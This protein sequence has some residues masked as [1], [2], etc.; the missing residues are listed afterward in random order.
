MTL[1]E[2]K[3]EALRLM[4][5]DRELDGESVGDLELDEDYGMLYTGTV[6]AINRALADLEARR[7]LPLKRAVLG[8]PYSM[9]PRTVEDAGPYKGK[10][11]AGQ[12]AYFL[13]DGIADLSLPARLAVMGENYVDEDCPY[14]FEAGRLRV[15]RYDAGAVYELLY[16]PS[17]ARVTH[18]TPNSTV[19]EL[20]EVLAAALPYYVKADLYRA[21][22]PGEAN[23]ARN[24]YESAVAQY[25]SLLHNGPQGSVVNVFEGVF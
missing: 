12:A 7:I 21:D 9:R 13:L 24:W 14:V 23:D 6:G 8:E 19:L 22:E 25:A 15:M 11:V 16:H 1:G 10:A 2:I 17:L 3:A 18:T 5:V 20:P 4:L